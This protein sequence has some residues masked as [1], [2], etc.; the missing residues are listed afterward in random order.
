MPAKTYA[1]NLI[2]KKKLPKGDDEELITR[3]Y[4]WGEGDS[5]DPRDHTEKTFSKKAIAELRNF[6]GGMFVGSITQLNDALSNVGERRR[7]HLNL[8]LLSGGPPCQSFSMAGRREK[9]NPR[10]SLPMHFVESAQLLTPKVVLLENVS[11]ITRPF[12]DN[13][14][15]EPTHAWH[16]IAYEFYK[17]KPGYVPICTL[18][19]A[20]KYGIPQKRARFVMVALRKDIAKK[21]INVLG[22]DKHPAWNDTIK[23]LKN[24]IAHF[25][26]IEQGLIPE[27]DLDGYKWIEPKG[28]WPDA[29]FPLAEDSYFVEHAIDDLAVGGDPERSACY[30]KKLNSELLNLS[31]KPALTGPLPNHEERNH[32][33]RVKARFRLLRLLSKEKSF[34]TKDLNSLSDE[35]IEYL[36]SEP[37]IFPLGGKEFEEKIPTENELIELVNSLASKKHSQRGIREGD[38]APA[39][40]SI[41]DD[42]AHYSDDRTLTVREMARIQSFPDWFEFRGKVTTGGSMRAFEVPQYTQVGNAVPPLMAKQIATGIKA[43]LDLIEE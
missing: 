26:K 4:A 10:N 39:Q 16:N 23:A 41:P 31:N 18:C 43:L 22:D 34:S 2:Y 7:K 17:S 28:D 8:D 35:Q 19:E 3:L 9:D 24:S 1:Y 25:T 6:D 21:A 33:P 14:S 5:D 37:L 12:K 27:N 20:Q 30:L 40:L 29:L 42:Y 15:K 38:H 11:G 13:A 36:M 32:S